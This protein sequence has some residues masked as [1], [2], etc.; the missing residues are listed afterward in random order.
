MKPTSIVL[1]LVA[2]IAG[3]LAAFLATQQSGPVQVVQ[4]PTTVVHEAKTQVLVAVAP[5]GVGERLSTRTVQWAD[6]PEGAVRADYVSIAA[7]PDALDDVSGAVARFEIFAGEP[8]IE[9]KLVRTGQGYMS[10]VLDKGKRGISVAVEAASASGGFIMPNDHVD[11]V[12]SRQAPTGLISE[13]IVH[14]VKVLAIN[15]RLGE[16]GTTGK[17]EDPES[18][19]TAF[20]SR[21][22]ATLE[23]DPE[24]GEAVI[25]AAQV[26]T[27]SLSL[28]SIADFA[29]GSDDNA[30]RKSN[31]NIRLI[32]FG[33]DTTVVAGQNASVEPSSFEEN[34]ESIALE[35]GTP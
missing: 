10:A 4:G 2:L 32:R 7:R 26:G 12:S 1:L 11:V 31:Q 8:I 21:S 29:P 28:R 17:P 30:R 15:L 6:W 5:I 14:N 22:I 33:S 25:N 34:S 13:T 19:N 35:G 23:L 20:Q 24:Q 3:G 18:P 9:Q 27:V 16:T